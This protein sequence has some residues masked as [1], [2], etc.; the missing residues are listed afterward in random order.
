MKLNNN[1]YSKDIHTD[2][3][4]FSDEHTKMTQDFT[5]GNS[6]IDKKLKIELLHDRNC[7]TFI[8]V[9]VAKSKI[10]AFYSLACSAC[11]VSSHRQHYFHP[12]VEVKYFAV[13]ENY[14]DWQFSEDVADGCL[15][16]IIFS[17][18]LRQIHKMS[19]ETFGADTIIL[20][21]TKNAIKFYEKNY[22]KKFEASILE[23]NERFLQGCLPM[24][25]KM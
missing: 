12:A 19:E 10:I 7:T 25:M 16:N 21:A 22:F 24:Y 5:C 2:T 18:M 17:D 23:N 13:D 8:V 4:L 9:D 11:V 20:Y 6:E 1:G 15:S 14:Q 3:V